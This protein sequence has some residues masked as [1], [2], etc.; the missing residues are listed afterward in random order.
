MWKKESR[1]QW[2]REGEHNT[3]SF[4]K[5]MVHH[6]QHNHI[7]FLKDEEG[8]RKTQHEEMEGLLVR[9]FKDLLTENEDNRL[10][11]IQRIM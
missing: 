10:D 7:Y 9:H 1:V 8:Q 4:H 5:A 3:R 11:V 6:R 2:L